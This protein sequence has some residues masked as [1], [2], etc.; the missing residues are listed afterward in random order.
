MLF[1]FK[2]VVSG[3][4][5][6]FASWLSGKR[7]ELAGF[8]IALPLMTLLVLPFSMAEHKDPAASVHF[9]QSICAAVPISMLFFVP[10]LIA[11][12]LQWG[13]WWLYGTGAALLVAGFFLHKFIMAQF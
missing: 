6:A 7:P 10:F 9:A 12:K 13:F 4:V 1:L 3:S 11:A 2:A 8:I 5:I